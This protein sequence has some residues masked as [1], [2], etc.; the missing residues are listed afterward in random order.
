M[1]YEDALAAFEAEK[2]VRVL[3]E[4]GGNADYA[5]GT[6]EPN[7][8]AEFSAWPIPEAEAV[9]WKLDG[10]GCLTSEE[11]TTPGE[12]SYI[13]DPAALPDTFYEGSGNDVWKADVEYDWQALPDG[14]G[15]GFIT[16]ELTQDTVVVGP[17]SV[18]LWI[19]ATA[20]DTDLEVTISEVRPDGTEIYVQSGWLRASQR[21][22]DE[23]A[24]TPLR[25]VHTN[26]EADAADLPADEFVPVRVELFPFAHPF[27]AGSRIRLTIDAPGNNRPVWEFRTISNGETVTIA[28][29]ADHPSQLVLSVVPVT[30]TA[31]A[32]PACGSLRGEPCRDY[33][34]AK[35]GG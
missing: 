15:V 35:N 28:H 27:R 12:S 26:L 22:L 17:G 1:T 9:S 8:T 32:P 11:L 6:P 23:T 19:K 21:A 14:K 31:P 25:P 16:P 34:A 33:V 29:D 13:A 4:Q 20:A 24:S 3:F 2:P 30:I 5:P 18:D 10:C 7:F